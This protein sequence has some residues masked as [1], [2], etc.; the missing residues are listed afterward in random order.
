MEKIKS[1]CANC[2]K[3][4]VCKY[5]K[6]MNNL[7][8]KLNEQLASDTSDLPFIINVFCKFTDENP[9]VRVRW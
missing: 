3:R 5:I 8:L 7:A 2:N 4:S 1:S 9:V 6:D